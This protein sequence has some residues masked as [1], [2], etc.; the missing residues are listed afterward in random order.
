ML[1]AKVGTKLNCAPQ[2]INKKQQAIAQAAPSWPARVKQDMQQAT[3][4]TP[5]L[6]HKYGRA[7]TCGQH[8]FPTAKIA[9]SPPA[10]QRLA[11]KLKRVSTTST[12]ISIGA[13]PSRCLRWISDCSNLLNRLHS[14]IL[15]RRRRVHQN[16]PATDTHKTPP[17][18]AK[19]RNQSETHAQHT[20]W[21]EN[22]MGQASKPTGYG[23]AREIPR[24]RIE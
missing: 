17:Q 11:H 2:G 21:T 12:A 22:C 5:E 20:R 19:I 24:R 6:T 18:N 23:Y 8:S 15:R 9:T 13:E 14:L 1:T 10:E 4:K 3:R 16:K 7:A